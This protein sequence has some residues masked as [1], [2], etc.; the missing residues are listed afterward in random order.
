ML[1]QLITGVMSNQIPRTVLVSAMR[2]DG[3]I[4]VNDDMTDEIYNDLLKEQADLNPGLSL[5]E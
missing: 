3:S 5:G 1:Q 2:R 4:G